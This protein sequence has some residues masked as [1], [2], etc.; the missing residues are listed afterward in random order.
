MPY[1][2]QVVAE[3]VAVPSSAAYEFAAKVENLPEW[4]SGLSS[5]IERRGDRW[6]AR[7]PM[8]EVEVV[9]AGPNSV[10]VLDHDV[11]LPDGKSVHNAFRV[12]PTGDGCVFTFV[13]LR[14]PGTTQAAFDADVAHVKADLAVLRQVL[15]K[16]WMPQGR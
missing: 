11:I 7:S 14:M 16:R 1:E 4:A 6:I 8:G 15:E 12:T 10:G 13:V 3:T 5:G 2:S 9:M